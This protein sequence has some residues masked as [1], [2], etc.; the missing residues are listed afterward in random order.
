MVTAPDLD[1]SF[2]GFRSKNLLVLFGVDYVGGD[3]SFVVVVGFEDGAGFWVEN[4]D[5]FLV[6]I[7]E[8]DD[9]RADLDWF[10]HLDF[11][12]VKPYYFK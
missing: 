3:F 12:Y 1:D 10:Q 5:L 9:L 2:L 11:Y 7:E 6:V 8:D 4:H